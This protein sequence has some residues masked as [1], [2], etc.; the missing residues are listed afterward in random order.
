MKGKASQAG[1]G[2][3]ELVPPSPRF[4]MFVTKDDGSWTV[5][6]DDEQALRAYRPRRGERTS[7]H[8]AYVRRNP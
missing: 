8:R 4:V 2:I 5:F 3:L 1:N 6:E 7:K